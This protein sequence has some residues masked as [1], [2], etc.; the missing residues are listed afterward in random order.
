LLC[1]MPGANV[2]GS[3]GNN[4]RLSGIAVGCESSFNAVLIADLRPDL[5]RP[6]R[7]NFLLNH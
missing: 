1:T 5:V 7:L 6:V 2:G 4:K 3:G